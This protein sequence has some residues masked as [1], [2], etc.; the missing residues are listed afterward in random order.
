MAK[1]LR[2]KITG[3]GANDAGASLVSLMAVF[4]HAIQSKKQL[5]FDLIF[6]ATAEEEISGKNGIELLLPQLG[7]VD[8]AIV[9]E[10]TNMQLAVAERGLMVLD[11]HTTGVAGHAARNEGENAIYKALSDINWFQQYSFAEQHPDLGN[12]SMQVTQIEAG[13]QHNVVPSACNFVVDVRSN[14]CY[15]NLE[16]LDI[17]QAH[18]HCKVTP[19]ST[20]LNASRIPQNHEIIDVAASI[21]ISS[22][23]S[24]TLSDQALMPFP[25][26]KIGPGD[27]ARSHTA[28]EYI[29]TT[30]IEEGIETYINLLSKLNLTKSTQ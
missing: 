26:V 29:F 25:T 12:V 8:F 4:L 18:V 21:G 17:I 9:G 11:C 16:I 6:A 20:R 14:S 7:I 24:P 27:S 1:Q 15:S 22:Y 3:L 19:R 13:S 5:P 30:E 10:P 28:D 2:G 23:G